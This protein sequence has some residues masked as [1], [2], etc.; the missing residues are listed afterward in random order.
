MIDAWRDAGCTH[1]LVSWPGDVRMLARHL[2]TRAAMVD[3]PAVVADLADE[4]APFAPHASRAL[5][6]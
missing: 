5:D 6:E 2:A 3:F 1:L 4:I